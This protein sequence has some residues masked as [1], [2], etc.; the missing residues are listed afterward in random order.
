MASFGEDSVWEYR[1]PF[2]KAWVEVKPDE[3]AKLKE[4]Y[5]RCNESSP[6]FAYLLNGVRFKTDFSSM[7]RT[8]VASQRTMELRLA[9]G[10]L[11]FPPPAPKP[12]VAPPSA[13]SLG[14]DTGE[15]LEKTIHVGPVP[16]SAEALTTGGVDTKPVPH[17]IRKAWGQ[18]IQPGVTMSQEFEFTMQ[19]EDKDFL[20]E[21]LTWNMLKAGIAPDQLHNQLLY[22]VDKAGQVVVN[23]KEG[24]ERMLSN[25]GSYPLRVL[26]KPPF[27]CKGMPAERVPSYQ[28][29]RT[30]LKFVKDAVM[31]VDQE[32]KN[33]KHWHQR[34]TFERF[35][36][37]LEDHYHQTEDKLD[38]ALSNWELYGTYPFMTGSLGLVDKTGPNMTR[39][40]KGEAD[41][42]EFLFGG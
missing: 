2:R 14:N 1:C 21:L 33:V 29:H 36:L 7:L 26:Y 16:L 18:G 5:L 41:I 23:N 22:F 10:D 31:N 17:S 30:F 32:I 12:G 25:P 9:R 3:D 19:L 40:L 13:A 35:L 34:R 24:I 4:A 27:W 37:Y 6:E 38:D 39:V 20:G 42:L 8:N 15:Q 11:P 28:I